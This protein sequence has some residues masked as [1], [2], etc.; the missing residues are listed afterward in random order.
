[1]A[2]CN[3]NSDDHC[4]YIKGK[5]CKHLEENTVPGRRWA[6]GLFRI[7]GSWGAVHESDGYLTDV[8]PDLED[9]IGDT[10]CGDWPRS[11]E[12]CATCGAEG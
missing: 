2:T 5:Q 9:I 11:G 8:K 7:F 10:N 4:C 12:R 1:M 3:G 6:C